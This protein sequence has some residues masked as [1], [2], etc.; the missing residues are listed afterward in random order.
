MS[1][2]KTH[3]EFVSEI[4]ALV[5]NEYTVKGTYTN[6]TTP[7][8]LLHNI[9]ERTF[10]V[11]PNNFL[12]GTRCPFCAKHGSDKGRPRK[13]DAQFRQDIK[14]LVGDEY[15]VEGTYQGAQISLTMRHN[16]CERT[17]PVRPSNF[18][19]GSRCPFCARKSRKK[20]GK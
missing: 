15:S 14:N 18:L 3:E 19:Y 17:F 6:S 4:A 1:R 12:H 2:K 11:R 7:V 5:G 10:S 16:I 9:C 8:K 20:K 13:T